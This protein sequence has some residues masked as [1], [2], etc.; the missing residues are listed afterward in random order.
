ME[1]DYIFYI[2]VLVY[3][4]VLTVYNTLYELKLSAIILDTSE[5]VKIAPLQFR[6]FNFQQYYT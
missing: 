3:C 5:I 4:C 1:S 6:L 2:T